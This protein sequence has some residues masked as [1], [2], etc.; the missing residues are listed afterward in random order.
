MNVTVTATA[1]GTVL[2]AR[3][4]GPGTWTDGLTVAATGVGIILAL[5]S[6]LL[7]YHE[8][9]MNQL[10]GLARLFEE[11][12]YF[13]RFWSAGDVV[14]QSLAVINGRSGQPF[15][16]RIDPNATEDRTSIP[17]PGE[18]GNTVAVGSTRMQVWQDMLGPGFT[19]NVHRADMDN[20]RALAMRVAYWLRAG[21]W[22]DGV[23]KRR[24]QQILAVFGYRLGDTVR[25]HRFVASRMIYVV[26]PSEESKKTQTWDYT[27]YPRAYG[28]FD[29]SYKSFSR[30][31]REASKA[32]KFGILWE[33]PELA[34]KFEQAVEKGKWPDKVEVPLT[35]STA[36]EP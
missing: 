28:L 27:H 26:P 36:T 32:E 10:Y 22:P 16:F 21:Y 29:E 24:A 6:A 23:R 20:F 11:Q 4:L 9:R 15:E 1:S 7:A 19:N 18:V 12:G 14:R 31:L 2:A 13:T 34:E 35:R 30:Y 3:L 5:V 8:F 17:V 25:R 33:A